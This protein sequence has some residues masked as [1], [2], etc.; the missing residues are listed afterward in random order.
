MSTGF[1][2]NPF[3][4]CFVRILGIEV[5]VGFGAGW[6]GIGLVGVGWG[7]LGP[8][9]STAF[10]NEPMRSRSLAFSMR[11]GLNRNT[12]LENEPMR[13]GNV[14]LCDVHGP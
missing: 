2:P 10:K 5:F 7:F 3:C 11:M 4:S 9:Q 12:P 13:D 8:N 6:H 1:G 14:D